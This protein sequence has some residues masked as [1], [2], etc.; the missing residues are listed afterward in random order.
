[1]SDTDRNKNR[2]ISIKSLCGN[3]MK[4]DG[5]SM[6]GNAPKALW[7]KWIKPD[8]Q[9]LIDIGSRSLLIETQEHKI[10]FETGA[11]AYL[12]PDMKKRFSVLDDDHILLQSL[13]EHGLDHTDITHIILSH[14]HFDHAGGL[15]KQW[16]KEKDPELLFPNAQYIVGKSNFERSCSPHI[17][18]RASFI[19]ELNALLENSNQL[20]LQKNGDNL[21]FGDVKIDFIESNGHTPGMLLSDILVH[22]LRIIFMG[23][24]IPGYPWVNLPITMGYDRNPEQLINEKLKILERA[25]NNKAFLFFTHDPVFAVSKLGFDEKRKRYIPEYPEEEFQRIVTV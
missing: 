2:H 8:E 25:Y 4:L 19:P 1:M 6:F 13:R 18:D 10:L 16:Q 14:L 20:V 11:G 5:G 17:R 7:Q 12:S 15:L 9:N 3:F 24:L 23:D 22:D 21:V